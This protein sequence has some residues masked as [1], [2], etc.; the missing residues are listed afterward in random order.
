MQVRRGSLTT[1][2]GPFEQ[3]G[4]GHEWLVDISGSSVLAGRVEPP[5]AGVRVRWRSGDWAGGAADT[6]TDTQGAFRFEGVAAGV[7]LVEAEGEQGSAAARSMASTTDLVLRLARGRLKVIVHDDRGA[8]VSDFSL[9]LVPQLGGLVRRFPVLSPTGTFALDLPAGKWRV[10]ASADGFGDASPQMVEVRSV[11]AEVRLG[12][13]RASP[14]RGAVR[15]SVSRLP[16]RG[17][18]VTIIRLGGPPG[19]QFRSLGRSSAGQTDGNGEFYA[20]AVALPASVEVRHSLYETAWQA[21]PTARD[22]VTRLELLMKP[23]R[24][25]AHSE[26]ILEYEGV[27]MQLSGDQGRIWIAQV[28]ENSPAELAGIQNGDVIVLVDGRPIA[29][30]VEEVV[31]QIV[32]PAGSVVKI[33]VRRGAE[34]LEFSVRRR[35]ITL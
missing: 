25:P 31:K 21:I 12:M 2:T 35:A 20:P 24:S 6:V 19:Q 11:E 29:A 33:T 9:T 7:L 28:Y 10:E 32:G 3:S 14:V 16:I 8:G 5:T 15:D 22:G 30:P 26:R 23:G 18:T 1:Q 27:G 4:E 17:A 13:M 34:T